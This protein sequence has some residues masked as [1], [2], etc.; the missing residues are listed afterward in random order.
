MKF[1]FR[2]KRTYTINLKKTAT[3]KKQPQTQLI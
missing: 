2:D 1:F 3:K